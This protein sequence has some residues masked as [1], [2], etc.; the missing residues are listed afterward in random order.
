MTVI[1]HFR[2]LVKLL[3]GAF[4]VKIIVGDEFVDQ[5]VNLPELLDGLQ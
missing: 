3:K 4:G 2:T 1:V 5:E